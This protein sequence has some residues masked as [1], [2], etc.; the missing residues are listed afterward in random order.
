M[1]LTLQLAT[2][3]DAGSF[4]DSPAP[5][6]VLTLLGFLVG[7][8]GHVVRSRLVV[9]TGIGMVFSATVLLPLVLFGNPYR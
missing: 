6:V 9:A 2:V 4:R 7:A 1:L 3:F 8:I 5:F